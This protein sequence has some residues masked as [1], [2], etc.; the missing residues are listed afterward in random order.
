MWKFET[1]KMRKGTADTGNGINISTAEYVLER[2]DSS[3]Y[4]EIKWISSMIGTMLQGDAEKVGYKYWL[5][6]SVY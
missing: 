1:R 6:K 5:R 2:T 3:L 4:L